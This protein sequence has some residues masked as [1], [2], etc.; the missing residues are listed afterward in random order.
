MRWRYEQLLFFDSQ[1]NL[2]VLIIAHS[3]SF[4]TFFIPALLCATVCNAME[5]Y[6]EEV[7]DDV[8]HG[9]ICSHGTDL[10]TTDIAT[11]FSKPRNWCKCGAIDRLRHKS[12]TRT[13][14]DQYCTHRQCTVG[15]APSMNCQFQELTWMR[16][17]LSCSLGI[18]LSL[19]SL[20]HILRVLDQ[21]DAQS[22]LWTW[23][24]QTAIWACWVG[25]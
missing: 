18:P 11:A 4:S 1:Y 16:Q 9:V 8:L 21:A 15:L 12:S 14:V 7:P 23:T 13:S 19:G 25:S 5:N 20:Y 24:D 10:P 3:L 2:H 6:V 22:P 17:A